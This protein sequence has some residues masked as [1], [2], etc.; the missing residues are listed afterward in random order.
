MTFLVLGPVLLEYANQSIPVLLVD[1]G[2][3]NLAED[4]LRFTIDG[5]PG[6]ARLY[7]DFGDILYLQGKN[8]EAIEAYQQ[9]IDIDEYLP[10]THNNLGV[11]LLLEDEADLA[12]DHFQITLKLNPANAEAYHNLGN[13]YYQLEQWESAAD[14]YQRAL[15]IDPDLLDVKAAWAATMLSQ[16]RLKEAREAWET[17]LLEDPGYLLA[18]QGY[19]VISVLEGNPAEALPYLEKARTADPQ[20]PT[21]RLYIGLA[22]QILERP[23]EAAAEF[24]FVLEKGADPAL[25]QLAITY[26]QRLQE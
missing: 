8:S 10:Q 21:T 1:A 15:E 4:Y 25:Q 6:S 14:A 12:A 5:Q 26:L 11:V 16:D 2:R 23:S 24:E 20:D 18:I 22:L 3:P 13:A 7:Q 17:I 19:G 9:A